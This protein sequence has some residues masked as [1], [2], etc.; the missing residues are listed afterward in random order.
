MHT[1][2]KNTITYKTR[3]W[4]SVN[5]RFSDRFHSPSCHRND[6]GFDAASFHLHVLNVWKCTNGLSKTFL[7][8]KLCLI[9][10]NTNTW[11]VTIT[12]DNVNHNYDIGNDNFN[13]KSDNGYDDI[14]HEDNGN[15][16]DK[17]DNCKSKN[18]DNN[19]DNNDYYYE[20]E[21]VINIGDKDT[22]IIKNNDIDD[23]NEKVLTWRQLLYKQSL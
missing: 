5:K 17:K 20:N 3:M 1:N 6:K 4:K 10:T 22:D 13:N 8:I 14:N 18:D 19:V 9:H 12:N 2:V 21:K 15:D 23:D 7:G 11:I 16:N